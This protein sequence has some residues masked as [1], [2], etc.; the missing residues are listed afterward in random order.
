MGFYL[1]FSIAFIISRS[2]KVN[3]NVK[4]FIGNIISPFHFIINSATK[5]VDDF[6]VSIDDLNN[7]RK[8]LVQTK[9]LLEKLKGASIEIAELNR[10]NEHLRSR[11]DIKTR[12]EYETVFAVIIAR[13]PS[14]YYSIFIINKG[15]IHG[16]KRNMPVVTYQR[17][18]K[19]IVGKI[20]E[21]SR[22]SSKVLPITGI[23]SYI[24]AM[25][26]ALRYTGLVKGQSHM[27]DYLLFD[28]VDKEAVLNFGDLVVASGQGGIYPR[29]L[30]IGKVVGFTKV[31][32]GI[33]YKSIRVKPI[34][35][36]SRLED[37]YVILK[38]PDLEVI[39]FNR[40]KS[41]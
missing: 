31:K 23:G 40:D 13:E 8:E 2:E 30:K 26:S 15:S 38:K 5:T 1:L 39:D 14:N 24:G 6:W 18:Q 4:S 25:L 33:F 21:T 41:N 36:F 28:Y 34:I 16:I 3:I 10:E 7:I 17:G 12:M 19:G 20:L 22:K 27:E 35:N 32:Y 11:L 9:Q 37:V 29:G